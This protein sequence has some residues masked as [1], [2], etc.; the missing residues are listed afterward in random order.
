MLSPSQ[1]VICLVAL[2]L[3]LY[4]VYFYCQ[5]TT[6]DALSDGPEE[7]EEEED[8][9]EEE[10]FDAMTEPPVAAAAEE[11]VVQTY[12]LQEAIDFSDVMTTPA[13]RQEVERLAEAT[14]QIQTVDER[15]N[16]A[17]RKVDEHKMKP[18]VF[19]N[20]KRRELV[21]N[22]VRR[23]FC[24]RR[25]RSWRTQFSDSIRGDLVPK[26]LENSWSMMRIGRSD[27]A[28][29][30]HPGALG[31]MSGLSGRWVSDENIPDNMFDDVQDDI[32]EV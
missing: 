5:P 1:F 3:A 2:A 24:T 32:P 4:G 26:N 17:K 25:T 9:E 23:P 27:P 30:L 18:G 13:Q 10:Y 16:A 29:D 28:V 20:K 19:T 15:Y 12:N 22:L 21:E 6:E 11:P 14:K 31:P 7:D 8:G